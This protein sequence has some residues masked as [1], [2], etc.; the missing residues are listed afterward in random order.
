MQKRMVKLEDLLDLDLNSSGKMWWNTQSF[1]PFKSL[2]QN[3]KVT[4]Y[5]HGTFL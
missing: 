2:Q 4:T 1:D 5:F 3:A